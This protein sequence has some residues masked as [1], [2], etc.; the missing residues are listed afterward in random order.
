MKNKFL[1]ISTEFQFID[2]LESKKYR[3]KAVKLKEQS[4]LKRQ[5]YNMK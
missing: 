1:K 5:Y 2:N 4:K 3:Y